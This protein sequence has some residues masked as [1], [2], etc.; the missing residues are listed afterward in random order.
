MSRGAGFPINDLLRRRLQSG[1]V[2]VTLTLS[3]ASTLFLLLFSSRVGVGLTASSN[4]FTIGLTSVFGQFILFMGILVF[5]VGAV[6]TS[7]IVSLMMAQ[8]T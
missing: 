6:L 4:V 1:L 8:R 7:F 2:V 3:V 5:L